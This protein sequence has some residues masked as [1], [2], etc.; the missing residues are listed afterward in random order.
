MTDLILHHYPMSPFSEKIRVMLGYAEQP[1]LSCLT[2]EMPPRPLM[3][4]LTGGY[5]KI[6]VAQIGGDIFCD[7][8][9]IAA[10]I[11]RLTQHPELALETLDE[12]QQAFIA[13]VD[14]ELFF[15]CLFNANPLALGRKAWD[16][17]SLPELGLLMWDRFKMGRSARVQPVSP[18]RARALTDAHL[19][20]LESRL[21]L[22]FLFGDTPT[23]ADFSAYHSLW[24]MCDLGGSRKADG[25]PRVRN[26]MRRMRAFGHG[27]SREITAA[28]AL[29]ATRS[30]P[31][32]IEFAGLVDQRIGSTV[33]IA[34]DDYGHDASR[35]E[36]VGVTPERWIL[37]RRTPSGETVHVHFP[38]R[39]YRLDILGAA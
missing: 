31:R 12:A 9:I 14:L 19:Q 36:L 17:L 21:H 5:R 7:S 13:R 15:A 24:F 26:W 25:F 6:P 3:E 4:A 27:R 38:V 32:A 29:A 16:S 2:R 1:W 37:R 10:E 34:P 39:G 20:D 33:A 23:H 30:G 28:E 11:A 22:D 18:S 35:G 8:R